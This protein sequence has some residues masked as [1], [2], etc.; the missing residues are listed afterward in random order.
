MAFLLPAEIGRPR[1]SSSFVSGYK[2]ETSE[3]DGV[4]LTLLEKT[5]QTVAVLSPSTRFYDTVSACRL[6]TC[7]YL[8]PGSRLEWVEGVT[9]EV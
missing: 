2:T 9:I 6:C 3:M 7:P 8:L 1:V 5:T 4:P